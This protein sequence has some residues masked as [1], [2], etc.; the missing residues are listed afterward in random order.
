[1][2]YVWFMIHDSYTLHVRK[3]KTDISFLTS[4]S[5]FFILKMRFGSN[6]HTANARGG[7]GSEG[8]AVTD[9]NDYTHHSHLLATCGYTRLWHHKTKSPVLQCRKLQA[10]CDCSQNVTVNSLNFA[11]ICTHWIWAP[12]AAGP[13]RHDTG[14]AWLIYNGVGVWLLIWRQ[15]SELTG[16]KP[17]SRL[18]QGIRKKVLLRAGLGFCRKRFTARNDSA[19]LNSIMFSPIL[20]LFRS[21]TI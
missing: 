4:S 18:P 10:K 16:V 13:H 20:K 14:E 9:F 11:A 6:T 2:F 1:M 7:R 19:L 17:E 5:H 3:G 12:A 21:V 15:A 8:N